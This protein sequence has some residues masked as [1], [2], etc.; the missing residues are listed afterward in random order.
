MN[1]SNNYTRIINIFQTSK[2]RNKRQTPNKR[3][4]YESQKKGVPGSF[5]NTENFEGIGINKF[6]N[7]PNDGD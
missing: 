2:A 1:L 7:D 3:S 6:L 5:G 4:F